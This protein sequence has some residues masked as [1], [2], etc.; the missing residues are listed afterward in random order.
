M[1]AK[2]LGRGPID[3]GFESRRRQVIFEKFFSKYCKSTASNIQVL[4]ANS[5]DWSAGKDCKGAS[6]WSN[7]RKPT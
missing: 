5:V 2:A 1:L 3:R 4:R 6:P 7:L